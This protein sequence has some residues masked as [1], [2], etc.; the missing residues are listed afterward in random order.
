MT[1]A[2]DDARA[3]KRATPAHDD[4][5]RVG[6]RAW[7]AIAGAATISLGCGGT[8]EGASSTSGGTP[9][10]APPP[11]DDG[12]GG[13]DAG[14][15]AA[16]RIP[17]PPCAETADDPEGPFYKAGAPER[18]SLVEAAM[19]GVRLTIRGFVVAAGPACTPLAG[20]VLDFWQADDAGAYD[21]AGF[22]L[23]GRVRSDAAGRYELRTI[24]P[25]RYLNGAQY[26]PAHIHV[27]VTAPG[28][29]ALTTQL[30]FDGDPFNAVDGMFKP[31]LV[32]R[33]AGEGSGGRAASF[34]FVLA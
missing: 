5:T 13:V 15:D 2:H 22:R 32:M 33:V 25:G 16:P 28:R 26:R 18:A 24:V 9:P 11:G 29:R 10:P 6:R 1:K 3:C 14:A 21:N 19:A 12:G 4:E 7:M 31:E 27:T 23:R 17:T 8:T 20:V 34:D 30:Y